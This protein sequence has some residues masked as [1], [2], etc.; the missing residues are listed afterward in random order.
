MV[1]ISW[2]FGIE[3]Y[4]FL[5]K[6]FLIWNFEIVLDWKEPLYKISRLFGING[7]PSKHNLSLYT[8]HCVMPV[9]WRL[10]I[11]VHIPILREKIRNINTHLLRGNYGN[12]SQRSFWFLQHLLPCVVACTNSVFQA[13]LS[14]N[15]ILL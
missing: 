1:V 6:K 10:K 15:E 2:L 8:F 12:W 11:R 3:N 9:F 13:L 5:L 14:F 4:V 7:T